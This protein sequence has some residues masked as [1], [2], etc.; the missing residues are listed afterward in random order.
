MAEEHY[1]LHSLLDTAAR[2]LSF[3][4][5]VQ[6]SGELEIAVVR[7]LALLELYKEGALHVEQDEPLGTIR[8]RASASA[9]QFVIREETDTQDAHETGEASESPESSE[10]NEEPVEEDYE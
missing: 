6:G 8:V 1:I 2:E 10:V 3:A 7:F 9:A 5:L 4:E